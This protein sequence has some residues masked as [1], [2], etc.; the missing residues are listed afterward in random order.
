MG[1]TKHSWL[2]RLG[3]GLNKYLNT[4]TGQTLVLQSTPDTVTQQGTPFSAT[5]M[6]EMENGI[7]NAYPLTF[8]AVSVNSSLWVSDTTYEDFPYKADIPLTGVT[9]DM[10]PTVTFDVPEA[11][12]GELAP[13]CSTGAGYVRIY[14]V[15]ALSTF[16][17]PSISLLEARS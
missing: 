9:A 6:N 7:F 16:T 14:A 13:V 8:S 11:T 2:A 1:Y 15:G 3:T 4:V 10:V 17:I 5:W 12:G